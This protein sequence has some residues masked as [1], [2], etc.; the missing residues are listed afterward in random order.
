MILRGTMGLEEFDVETRCK[1]G[2]YHKAVLAELFD[3]NCSDASAFLRACNVAEKLG[4]PGV[5]RLEQMNR[6]LGKV[7]YYQDDKTQYDCYEWVGKVLPY[8][9]NEVRL[10]EVLTAAYVATIRMA[11]G[12]SWVGEHRNR[13]ALPLVAVGAAESCLS[14][15]RFSSR[16]VRRSYATVRDLRSRSALGFQVSRLV[17]DL[18]SQVPHYH[19]PQWYGRVL[20]AADLI[21]PKAEEYW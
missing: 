10:L 2:S 17:G 16:I 4:D 8:E 11:S 13:C 5:Y 1:E 7:S 12:K 9:T 19:R 21:C 3:P 14:V 20:A 6:I 15:Y 18:E